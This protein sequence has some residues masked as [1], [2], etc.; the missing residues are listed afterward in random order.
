MAHSPTSKQYWGM[1]KDIFTKKYGSGTISMTVNIMINITK[2]GFF[3]NC[4][5]KSTKFN[6]LL[7]LETKTPAT[8]SQIQLSQL[9]MILRDPP[10]LIKWWDL[11]GFVIGGILW[12]FM[13]Q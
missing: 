11:V 8:P 13:L 1:L 6:I 9:G 3:K 4:L 12:Y 10:K 2:S 7:C 5:K